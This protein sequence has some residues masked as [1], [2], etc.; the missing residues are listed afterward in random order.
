VGIEL[1]LS[2]IL[3]VAAL[4]FGESLVRT[5]EEIWGG[6][7]WIWEPTVWALV[8]RRRARRAGYH[9]IHGRHTGR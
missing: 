2:A 4:F 3:S 1:A 5:F 6:L 9:V 8:A 7:G